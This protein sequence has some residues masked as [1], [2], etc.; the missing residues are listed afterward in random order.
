[1]PI[2]VLVIA[3]VAGF[4]LARKSAFIVTAVAWAAGV[5][6]VGFNPAGGGT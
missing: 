6:L 5:L 4:L 3:A 2:L 1:M